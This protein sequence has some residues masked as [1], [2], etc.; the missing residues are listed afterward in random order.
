M[1]TPA[2]LAR[3]RRAKNDEYYTLPETVAEQ[4]SPH[5]AFLKGKRI[6]C[7]CD[8]G[9]SAF[10]RYFR[11]HGLDCHYTSTDFASSANQDQLDRADLVITNPPF[12]LL[13]DYTTQLLRWGGQFAII[14]PVIAVSNN[15]I[16]HKFVSGEWFFGQAMRR[17]GTVFRTPDGSMVPMWVRWWTNVEQFR[18]VNRPI[19]LV[20]RDLDSYRRYDNLARGLHIPSM[21][22]IPTGYDGPMG[23]PLTYF[24][25]HCASQFRLVGMSNGEDGRQLRFK[26]GWRPFHR[27]IIEACSAESDG[28][29]LRPCSSPRRASSAQSARQ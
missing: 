3:A 14:A 19:K 9:Q 16:S 5:L 13:Q 6:Y 12:S 1:V 17:R 11:E 25:H 23:V 24:D 27:V 28:Q 22:E 21:K 15:N 2:G 8:T 10:V 26:G 18:P 20:Q 29:A 4:F 7:N